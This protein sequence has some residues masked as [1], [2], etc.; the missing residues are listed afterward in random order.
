MFFNKE[1]DEKNEIFN[2]VRNNHALWKDELYGM[3][4]PFFMIP[5]DFSSLFLRDI[6]GGAL[7]L[8]LFLG[9]HAKYRTGESW[10]SVEQISLFFQK[11]ERTIAKWFNELE[12]LGLIF[13]AQ[14][15]FMMKANT[16]ILPYGIFFKDED[17]YTKFTLLQLEEFIK[18]KTNNVSEALMLNSGTDETS[19]ILLQKDQDS[20]TLYR[21]ITFLNI[22][23]EN[24][25]K[26]KL[27][28]ENQGIS[29]P[30]SEIALPVSQSKNIKQTLYTHLIGFFDDV[31]MW[32]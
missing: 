6:S 31:I 18:K 8:Y 32:E 11:D 27:L 22:G 15:G 20:Q 25:K 5:T 14:K 3:N 12:K 21:G 13:R 30:T 17:I 24:R 16:F 19:L 10:Y 1:R 9:S 29:C 7:K 4:K 2:K 23:F 28:C 26:I